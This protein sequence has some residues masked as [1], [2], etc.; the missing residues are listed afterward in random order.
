[1]GSLCQATT[2]IATQV[3]VIKVKLTVIRSLLLKI[4]NQFTLNILSLLKPIDTK[5]SIWVACIETQFGIATQV[6]VNKVEVTVA[7]KQSSVFTL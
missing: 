4:E 1:M 3:S 7:E 5:L 2:W 6:S